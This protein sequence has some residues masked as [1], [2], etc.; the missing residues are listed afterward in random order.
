MR[1]FDSRLSSTFPDIDGKKGTGGL[2][3]ETTNRGKLRLKLPA[4]RSV[5]LNITIPVLDLQAPWVLKCQA[6]IS[7]TRSLQGSL[8]PKATS[9]GHSYRRACFP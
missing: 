4:R 7:T 1:E 6:C 2:L 8:H 9:K 5:D 3:A